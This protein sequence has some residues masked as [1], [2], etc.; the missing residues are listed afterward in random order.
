MGYFMGET[1][2]NMS[3][4]LTFC[5]LESSNKSDKVYPTMWERGKECTCARDD[6]KTLNSPFHTGE[7]NVYDGTELLKLLGSFAEV[8]IQYTW[9]I[10]FRVK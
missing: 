7:N 2:N 3:L 1:R 5:C 6:K 9:N 10:G 8:K 4:L